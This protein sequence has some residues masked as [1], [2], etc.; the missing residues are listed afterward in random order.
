[1]EICKRYGNSQ[2]F[3]EWPT[4]RYVQFINKLNRKYYR[5]L[6]GLL[7]RH[8]NLHHMPHKKR[9]AKTP[10][11]RRYGAEKEMSELNLCESLAQE[12]LRMQTLGLTENFCSEKFS[13]NSGN[14]ED[15]SKNFENIRKHSGFLRSFRR[16]ILRILRNF[17]EI[18]SKFT[19]CRWSN[20]WLH[21]GV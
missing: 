19:F 14:F 11:C 8:I 7:N 6:V 9:R 13:R 10:S 15:I 4:S 16:K 18:K 5:M 20:K 21:Y 2:L 1:M 17:G 3:L 12:N